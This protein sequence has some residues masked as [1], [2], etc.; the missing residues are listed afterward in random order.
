M[1]QVQR[2]D[3]RALFELPRIL[4]GIHRD[5]RHAQGIGSAALAQVDRAMPAA[6]DAAAA[7]AQAS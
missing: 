6:N 5:A 4:A 2:M 7:G 3:N 1:A